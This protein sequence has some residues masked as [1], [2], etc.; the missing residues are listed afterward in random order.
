MPRCAAI[1]SLLALAALAGGC[2]GMGRPHGPIK[3][4]TL[5]YLPPGG[6]PITGTFRATG[7]VADSGTVLD[8]F[9]VLST[10]TGLSRAAVERTLYSARGTISFRFVLLQVRG[11]ATGHWR[12]ESGTGRYA[13]LSGSGAYAGRIEFLP[14][15][16]EKI[17]DT[18]S[19]SVH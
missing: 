2:G 11:R 9:K 18:M 13:G 16:A 7:A 5:A 12:I 6:G 10:A 19:G 4:A 1:A 15:G 3:V 17:R 14:K 8:T